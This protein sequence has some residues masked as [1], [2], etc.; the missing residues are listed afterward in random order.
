MTASGPYTYR[1]Y[2]EEYFLTIVRT[3]YHQKERFC[4]EYP[5]WAHWYQV[6]PLSP[7]H[8]TESTPQPNSSQYIHSLFT[9]LC[10]ETD[11]LYLDTLS[12][13]SNKEMGATEH[14]PFSLRKG[15]LEKWLID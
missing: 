14:P 11:R 12:K 1:H 8:P 10:E 5:E 4:R 15:M 2:K 7:K 6:R 13:M 9:S 3:T